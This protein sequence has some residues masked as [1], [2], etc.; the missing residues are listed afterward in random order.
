MTPPYTF[1]S[2]QGWVVTI[3]APDQTNAAGK[4]RF[5]SWSDG[6]A[7]THTVTTPAAPTTYTATFRRLGK[8]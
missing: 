3:G 1:T 7:R 5:V 8:P 2:W 6:G 4:W